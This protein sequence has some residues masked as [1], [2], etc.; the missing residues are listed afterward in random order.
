MV[1]DQISEESSNLSKELKVKIK[2]ENEVLHER[3]DQF[4]N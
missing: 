4:K 1:I 3:I 2:Q